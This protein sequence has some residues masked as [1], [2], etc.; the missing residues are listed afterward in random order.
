MALM[1]LEKAHSPN[2]TWT[3]VPLIRP[4]QDSRRQAAGDTR[5]A[6]R[7]QAKEKAAVYTYQ[8]CQ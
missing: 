8:S 5:E 1:T 6:R 4:R 3:A 7:K 2:R